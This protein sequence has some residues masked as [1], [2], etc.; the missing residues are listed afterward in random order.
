M[1]CFFNKKTFECSICL[2]DDNNKNRKR[3]LNCGHKFHFTCIEYWLKN[4]KR[5][6]LCNQDALP[7]KEQLEKDLKY[8]PNR[9]KSLYRLYC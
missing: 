8:I 5:C 7:L 9:F 3:K 1:S 6:P 4:Y 2:D